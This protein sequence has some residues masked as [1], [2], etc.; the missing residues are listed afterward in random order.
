M[1][2]QRE[3][4]VA[5]YQAGRT[6]RELAKGFGFHRETVS[7]ALARA[8]VPRR[9]HETVGVDLEQVEQLQAGGMTL[10]QIARFLGVGRTTLVRARRQKAEFARL[11]ARR[12]SA[13]GAYPLHPLRDQ[14]SERPGRPGMPDTWLARATAFSWTTWHAA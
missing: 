13:S 12:Y 5:G 11:V 1:T 10:A 8:G 4:L 2:A 14:E 6:L 3:A 7:I 9:Y